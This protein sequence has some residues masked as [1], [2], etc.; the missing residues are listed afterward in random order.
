MKEGSLLGAA[1][2][3]VV[4]L[5]DVVGE[6]AAGEVAVGSNSSAETCTGRMRIQTTGERD[7]RRVTGATQMDIRL[8]TP[9][10]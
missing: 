4:E 3:D 1:V 2:A 7:V 8:S 5:A 10:C 6:L 9:D